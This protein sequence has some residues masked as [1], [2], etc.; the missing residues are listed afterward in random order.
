MIFSGRYSLASASGSDELVSR[1]TFMLQRT[2]PFIK[3]P[4]SRET[5]FAHPEYCQTRVFAV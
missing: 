5:L 2:T 1:E 3:K 4:V